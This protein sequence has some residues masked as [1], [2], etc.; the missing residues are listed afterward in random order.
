LLAF[1]GER[2]TVDQ[3][4]QLLGT[5]SDDLIANLAGTVFAK[6]APQALKV[7]ADGLAKGLQPGELL[8]QLIEYW[9]DLMLVG[10]GGAE[11]IGLN[12]APRQRETVRQRGKAVPLDTILAGLDILQSAKARLRG[13]SHGRVLVEMALVRLSR[14]DDLISLSQLAQMIQAGHEPTTGPAAMSPTPRPFPVSTASTV[15]GSSGAEGEGGKKKSYDLSS[16]I[17]GTSVANLTLE[18]LPAVWT[19]V[20]NHVGPILARELE[21]GGVP[22]ISG[23]NHLVLQFSP[24]YNRQREHCSDPT[25]L[26]RVQEALKRVTGQT[27]T[28]RLEPRAR[29]NGSARPEVTPNLTPPRPAGAMEHPLV[30]QLIRVLDAKVLK[31]DDGFGQSL[32]S[33]AE[34]PETRPPEEP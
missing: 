8:D 25:R 29:S 11:V 17:N 26:Q 16:Q 10:C 6:D 22:A 32:D 1:G 5:A 19:E 13:S 15:L 12:A 3:V 31:V 28:V 2:L 23:P 18:N 14:L 27:W 30:Q 34:E 20:L 9:R 7:F 21:K 33:T 24:E 4:H